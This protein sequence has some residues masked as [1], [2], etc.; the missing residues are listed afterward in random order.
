MHIIFVMI[1]YNIMERYDLKMSNIVALNSYLI[2][3]FQHACGK[4]S[5][6][7]FITFHEN[8][9]FWLQMLAFLFL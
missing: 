2:F 4:C 1:R 7:C 9:G 3:E 6:G 8:S 5:Y